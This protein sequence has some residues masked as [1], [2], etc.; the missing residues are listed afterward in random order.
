MPAVPIPKCA[1]DPSSNRNKQ[2]A[3]NRCEKGKNLHSSVDFYPK[4][5]NLSDILPNI[6]IRRVRSTTMPTQNT[7]AKSSTEQVSHFRSF[8]ILQD[9]KHKINLMHDHFKFRFEVLGIASCNKRGTF[10]KKAFRNVL[11]RSRS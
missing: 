7:S 10:I 3:K 5:R 1:R 4:F 9:R 2:T 11:Q 6:P 8:P